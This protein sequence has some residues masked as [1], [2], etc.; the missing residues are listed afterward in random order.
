MLDGPGDD[1][2]GTVRLDAPVH[3]VAEVAPGDSPAIWRKEGGRGV[4]QQN[5]SL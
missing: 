4:K 1:D 2:E 3:D 5:F